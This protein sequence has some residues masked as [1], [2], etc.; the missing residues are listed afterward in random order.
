MSVITSFAG[1]QRLTLVLKCFESNCL[2]IAADSHLY[3]ALLHSPKLDDQELSKLLEP[4]KQLYSLE[5]SR[6]SGYA[7]VPSAPDEFRLP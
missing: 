5:I 4:A 2:V 3:C 1:Q 7:L 6:T